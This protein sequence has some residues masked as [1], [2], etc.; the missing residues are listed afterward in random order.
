MISRHDSRHRH[1]LCELDSHAYGYT[2]D[3]ARPDLA[4]CI[5]NESHGL[6]TGAHSHGNSDFRT[7]P[8]ELRCRITDER[9]RKAIGTGNTDASHCCRRLREICQQLLSLH[10]RATD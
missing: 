9:A 6:V 4:P 1:L 5:T 8:E 10:V 2:S 7:R 3:K